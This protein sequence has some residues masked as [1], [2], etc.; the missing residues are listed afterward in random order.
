MTI[1]KPLIKRAKQAIISSGIVNHDLRKGAQLLL[2][3]LA[4]GALVKREAVHA[5][6]DS[7][8]STDI[9]GSRY[10]DDLISQPERVGECRCHRYLDDNE[11]GIRSRYGTAERRKQ[12]Q[13]QLLDENRMNEC[14]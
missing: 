6:F 10:G 11:L 3:R 9:Q 12:T 4:R 7:P 13:G 8:F 2:R 14:V 5:T 1:S